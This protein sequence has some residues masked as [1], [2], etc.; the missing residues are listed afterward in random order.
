VTA[1][2]TLQRLAVLRHRS[3]QRALEALV[4]QV[5]LLR[6]AERQAAE[7]TSSTRRHLHEA[8]DRER[9]LIN[10]LAG[11]AVSHATI[12]R[13]QTELDRAALETVRL[14]AATA[15]AQANLLNRRNARAEA[16]ANFRRRQRAATALDLVCKQEAARGSRWDAALNEAEDE[17][18]APTLPSP[19]PHPALL[20]S[21]ERWGTGEGRVGVA[22]SPP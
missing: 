15:R 16:A 22:G 10:S 12:I 1:D 14:R 18:R 17:D 8:R 7:T 2:L 4:V 9:E 21:R 13:T 6:R 11:R 3:A 19:V 5:D 20:R